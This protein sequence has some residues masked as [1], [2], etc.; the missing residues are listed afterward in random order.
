MQLF[1]PVNRAHAGNVLLVAYAFGEEPIAD[2]PCEHGRVFPLVVG[3]GVDDVGRGHFRFAP[4]NHARF[5]ATRFVIPIREFSK[6]KT[7][8]NKTPKVF[9]Q[10]SVSNAESLK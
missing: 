4:A 3:Y 5:E 2:F 1:L 10:S 6:K 7:Q 8:I 9:P